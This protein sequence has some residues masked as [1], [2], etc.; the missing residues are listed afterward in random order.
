MHFESETGTIQP[1]L[2]LGVFVLF[3]YTIWAS[4]ENIEKAS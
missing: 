3:L 1:A 2:C 4:G